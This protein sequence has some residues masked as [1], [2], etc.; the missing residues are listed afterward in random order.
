MS[1][2]DA[3]GFEKLKKILITCS[4]VLWLSCGGI[5]D[6]EQPFFGATEGLLER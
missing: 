5:V 6:A 1:D 4:N 2:M 3:A